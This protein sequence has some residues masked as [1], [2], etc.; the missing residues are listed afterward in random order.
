MIDSAAPP[1]NVLKRWP[2]VPF[3]STQQMHSAV[4]VMNMAAATL[5]VY[6]PHNSGRVAAMAIRRP[7]VNI[8][9]NASASISLLSSL[10][11]ENLANGNG[12]ENLLRQLVVNYTTELLFGH[13]SLVEYFVVLC[14]IINNCR[15]NR[16]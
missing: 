15:R 14:S 1:N 9:S 11:G 13:C 5:P 2:N 6:N 10:Y 7:Q 16:T 12:R 8:G 4:R 3:N